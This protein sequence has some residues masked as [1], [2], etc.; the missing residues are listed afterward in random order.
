MNEH[1]LNHIFLG[2]MHVALSALAVSTEGS[3][4]IAILTAAIG[5][6]YFR[7]AYLA[8]NA[9]EH[10]KGSESASRNDGVTT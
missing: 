7:L 2:I 3:L 10:K 9:P 8:K 6:L 4:P 5:G 1:C